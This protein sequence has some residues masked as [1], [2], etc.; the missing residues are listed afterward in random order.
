MALPRTITT[1]EQEK[2]VEDSSGDVA[3]RV[4]AEDSLPVS[5]GLVTVT[6]SGSFAMSSNA[7]T[8]WID[9]STLN[10]GGSGTFYA[11]WDSSYDATDSTIIMEGA[12]VDTGSAIITEFGGNLGGL[13]IETAGAD[14]MG[15][16]FTVFT[17]T[18][19]RL[20]FTSNSATAGTLT[21]SFKGGK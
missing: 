19:I 13:V 18:F 9:V 10:G 7:D 11:S 4:L 15:F 8:A 20:A 12:D 21:W 17:T 3:V 16:E 14:N 6:S 2:F 5:V 1:R